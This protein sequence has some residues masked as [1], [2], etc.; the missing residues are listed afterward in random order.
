MT[1]AQTQAAQLPLEPVP[2]KKDAL[3]QAYVAHFPPIANLQ[4]SLAGVL[5]QTRSNGGSLVRA[6]IASAVAFAGGCE[7]ELSHKIGVAVEYFHT[8]SLLIDDL[9]SMDDGL[10]RRGQP[11]A[12]REFGESATLLGALALINRGH[13]LIW[14]VVARGGYKVSETL[15]ELL[16]SC[17]GAAGICNG[18]ALDLSYSP[19][20][21]GPVDVAEIADL[22]TGSLF[23]LALLLPA[24]IVGLSPKL[25]KDLETVAAHWGHAYQLIDDV[26]DE[27]STPSISGKT[28]QQD[29]LLHRP[30]MI[31]AEGYMN[32]GVRLLNHLVLAREALKRAHSTHSGLA[33][34]FRFQE[35]LE[36]R[37]FCS[38]SDP[39]AA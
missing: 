14:E 13:S 1:H 9:P 31:Q 38:V 28:T 5:D 22:K 10:M 11:C 19:L 35:K 32:A 37:I 15:S 30:N 25:Q 17:L 8:A 20:D 12:H 4:D 18:Q 26:V 29:A 33:L 2:A 6:K 3:R 27:L 23:R 34:L 21:G 24:Q 39:E 16:E 36:Q 7:E